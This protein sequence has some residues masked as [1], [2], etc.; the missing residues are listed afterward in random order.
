MKMLKM[1]LV[2]ACAFASTSV[3]ASVG[4][5]QPKGVTSDV[6]TCYPQYAIITAD[7]IYI[8]YDCYSNGDGSY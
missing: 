2:A 3:G 1:A 4:E 8:V 7:A 6:N 5:A